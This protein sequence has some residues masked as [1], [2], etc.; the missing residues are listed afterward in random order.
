MFLDDG[1]GGLHGSMALV[2]EVEAIREALL[3]C[4]KTQLM[5][6]EVESDSRFLMQM[7]KGERSIDASVEAIIF[8][9]KCKNPNQN[10]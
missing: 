7:L 5:H 3:T 2:M 10:I 1:M 6:V 8:D 4:V 9:I